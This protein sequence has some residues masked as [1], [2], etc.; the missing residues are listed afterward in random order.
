MDNVN[1]PDWMITTTIGLIGFIAYYVWR[2]SQ[3]LGEAQVA[4]S[5]L[6][7]EVDH[8]AEVVI[9]L[10]EKRIALLEKEVHVLNTQVSMLNAENERHRRQIQRLEKQR[11]ED[12]NESA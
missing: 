1:I 5:K 11:E 8:A 2:T 10:Q 6:D 12:C 3:G 7:A 9:A 4:K